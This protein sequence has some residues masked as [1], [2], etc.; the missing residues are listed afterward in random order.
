MPGGIKTNS[1]GRVTEYD[2]PHK[3]VWEFRS[4]G[5]LLTI[6]YRLKPEGSG[7]LTTCTADSIMPWRLLGKALDKLFMAR[8]LARNT[9]RINADL[10]R[11]L[12]SGKAQ[13]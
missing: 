12:E 7:N 2:R 13:N 3:L 5:M 8:Y 4:A 10:K 1:P 6:A 9:E 11:L